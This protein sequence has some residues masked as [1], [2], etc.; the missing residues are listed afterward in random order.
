M[1]YNRRNMIRQ[2][3]GVTFGLLA[4]CVGD[5]QSND[6]NTRHSQTDDSMWPGTVVDPEQLDF[7]ARIVGQQTAD[8]PAAVEVELINSSSSKTTIMTGPSLLL[9]FGGPDSGSVDWSEEL[10]L[11]PRA[12]VGP[13]STPTVTENGCYRFPTDG[14]RLARAQAVYHELASNDSIVDT[15]DI[16]TYGEDRPCLPEGSYPYEDVVYVGQQSNSAITRL[17]LAVD[18]DTTIHVSESSIYSR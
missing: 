11:D 12:S 1:E 18:K 15:F 3:G 14:E 9:G 17:G 2:F 10:V 16:Y 5:S 13:W 6:E 4:G 8:S 7:S